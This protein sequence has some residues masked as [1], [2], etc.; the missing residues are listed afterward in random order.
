MNTTFIAGEIIEQITR[1]TIKVLGGK[2][3]SKLD[4]KVAKALNGTGVNKA[5][6]RKMWQNKGIVVDLGV[7]IYSYNQTR[8]KGGSVEAGLAQASSDALIPLIAGPIKYLGIMIAGNLPDMALDAYEKSAQYGR[9]I[10]RSSNLTFSNAQF[11]D[12]EQIATMRQAGMQLAEESQFNMK[13]AMLGNEA[14]Y[15]FKI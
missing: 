5:I 10:A 1:K 11:Q 7:G 14:K 2:A 6:A 8:S 9:S 15:N 4:K 3:V 12:N 13:N